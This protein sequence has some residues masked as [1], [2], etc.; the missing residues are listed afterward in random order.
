MFTSPNSMLPVHMGRR[1]GL[2]ARFGVRFFLA[3]L[4]RGIE[5]QLPST[6]ASD[7]SGGWLFILNAVR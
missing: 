7:K 1:D 4:R 6:L 2:P 3:C 5:S